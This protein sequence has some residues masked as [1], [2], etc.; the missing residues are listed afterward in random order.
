MGE[1]LLKRYLANTS[2]QITSAGTRGLPSSR[3][4]ASSA[5]LLNSVGIDSSTFRSR[6]LTQPMAQRADLILCFEASQRKNI[7]SLAPGAVH[8]TFLLN[9][10][11]NMSQSCAAHRLVS[12]RTVQDRLQS[13]TDASTYIRP[14]L[15]SVDDIDDP[16]GKDFQHFEQAAKET[17]DA[18]KTI[19]GSLRKRATMV[20][21][22]NRALALY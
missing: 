13:I 7:V 8:Y 21:A 11:A 22:R 5:R 4:H 10:F 18:L 9:D 12:G 17:N 3:I 16:N 6:R 14:M 15:P 20:P 2:V 1:L 19:L